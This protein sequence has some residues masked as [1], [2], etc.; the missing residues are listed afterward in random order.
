MPITYA[1]KRAILD[2]LSDAHHWSNRFDMAFFMD[3]SRRW[4]SYSAGDVAYLVEPEGETAFLHHKP[5]GATLT[6][7]RVGRDLLAEDE[8]GRLLAIEDGRPAM[9]YTEDGTFSPIRSESE[10][11]D[12][13]NTAHL[14]A[15]DLHVR[16]AAD[17]SKSLFFDAGGLRVD[18]GAPELKY[19][20]RRH[21]GRLFHAV[22]F[23]VGD[24]AAFGLEP[25]DLMVGAKLVI[26]KDLGIEPEIRAFNALDP[27]KALAFTLDLMTDKWDPDWKGPW[28][29]R[30]KLKPKVG[31]ISP[32]QK[33]WHDSTEFEGHFVAV[34]TR[35]TIEKTDDGYSFRTCLDDREAIR[36]QARVAHEA[37]EGGIPTVDT[38]AARTAPEKLLHFLRH[39][40]AVRDHRNREWSC[41]LA[42]AQKAAILAEEARAAMRSHFGLGA[43]HFAAVGLDRDLC[44]LAM[45]ATA[46][47][48]VSA[49]NASSRGLSAMIRRG[50]TDTGA[51]RAFMEGG[52]SYR[53][54][55]PEAASKGRT[56]AEEMLE[57]GNTALLAAYQA[58]YG[59]RPLGAALTPG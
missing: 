45:D 14:P 31:D 21:P 40:A 11:L 8:S 4:K 16:F 26:A 9:E 52:A 23:T 28:Q 12:H 46:L 22:D 49:A 42:H 57:A 35:F 33:A 36:A 55:D 50:D 7:I 1:Q 58:I 59:K 56:F 15:L 34:P 54:I 5:S 18:I 39:G 44:V 13:A 48:D 6:V 19:E 24:A 2:Y 47:E 20:E 3:K 10:W 41:V 29:W 32:L 30:P 27:E 38:L 53:H 37:S 43:F 51:M 25:H 17:G